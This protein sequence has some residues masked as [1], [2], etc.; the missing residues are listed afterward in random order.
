MK[1]MTILALSLL[2]AT[3]FAAE[4]TPP[5]SWKSVG[6]GGGGGLW[7]P[8]INPHDKDEIL[9]ACDMGEQFH[10]TD[11]G[12][13]WKVTSHTQMRVGH[14]SPKVQFSSDPK[15]RYAVDYADEIRRPVKSTDGGRTWHPLAADPTKRKAYSI[16]AD[17][18][19][20]DR[21][22]IAS[23][24]TLYASMDGGDSFKKVFSFPGKA[25]LHIG[26]AYFHGDMAV[27]GTNA[28][29]L[30][31]AN[32]GRSFRIAQ[33]GGI[34]KY[35]AIMS[36]AGAVKDGK[37][38]FACITLDSGS[39]R[40]GANGFSRKA[41]RGVYT[42]EQGA[43]KW[44]RRVTGIPIAG[45]LALLSMSRNNPDVIY[46]GGGIR[47]Y[48][49]ICKSE[50][51]GS[52]WRS[53]FRTNSNANI[54]TGWSGAGGDR[55]W[56]Y[57]EVILGV[58][59]APGDPNRV[60]ITDMGFIHFTDDGGKSWRQ[61]Y[62]APESQNPASAL[63]PKRRAY[64]GAGIENTSCWN[65]TWSDANNVWAS[66]TDI[67]GLR[68]TD[69]GKAWGFTYTGHRW[70]TSYDVVRDAKMDILFMAAS[71]THDLYQSTYL[72]DRRIDKGKG[73]VR[74]STDRGKSWGDFG[75]IK[76]PVVDLA[77]DPTQANRIYA[78]VVH[79][80]EGGIYVCEDTRNLFKPKWRR[81]PAPPRTQGHPYIIRVLNDGALAVTYSG[82]RAGKRRRFTASSG[83]FYSTDGGATWEDRSHPN[84][85]YW[86]KDIII[87]PHDPK[88]N[89]WYVAVFSGWGG[90]PNNKGGL[91][92]TTDR[93][94]SWTRLWNHERTESIT[95]HPRHPN[96][97]YITTEFKGLFL[98]TNLTAPTPTIKPVPAYPFMHPM[99]V[100]FNPH[101]DG[102]IWITSFGNGLRVGQEAH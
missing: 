22:F 5:A 53:V 30:S 76:R 68:S 101:K 49:L 35:E 67:R 48:P 28:G 51:G 19:R 10:S 59:V 16:W 83:V 2:C 1:P 79:S 65:L 84:M 8:S 4:Y 98:T 54:A 40:V 7:A 39:V 34:P 41:Y 61:G 72:E 45:K 37:R 73:A 29:L 60:A 89:T 88:Q 78:S 24:N 62:V 12:K 23:R 58:E 82:R 15:I 87:D 99:R 27:F 90:A 81:L 43:T 18:N 91:Y 80:R 42:L 85:H 64:Q 44:V 57:G 96:V 17:W 20:A 13:S 9:L 14:H 32:G 38:R 86:T 3:A 63:T 21:I 74:F 6:V 77:L 66:F 55:D 31:S 70:N 100:I 47:N 92:R 102:E 26:G 50:D 94:K 33:I 56:G 97:A 95:I 69:G 71:S 25:G 93:G 52:T 75:N 46:V 36:F 11:A